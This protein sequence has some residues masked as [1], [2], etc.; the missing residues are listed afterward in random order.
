M[1][2]KVVRSVF[3]FCLLIETSF[4][5]SQAAVIHVGSAHELLLV[6][7]EVAEAQKHSQDCTGANE[8][9]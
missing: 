4:S 2:S 6:A 7:I 5:S 1:E 3:G 9:I 8:T